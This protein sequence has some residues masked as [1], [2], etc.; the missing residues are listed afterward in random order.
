MHEN[1]CC[2]PGHGL[3]FVPLGREFA[4]AQTMSSEAAAHPRIAQAI[5]DVED[6]IAYMEAAPNDFGGP[7]RRV[8]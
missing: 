2:C 4:N 7:L 8:R 1:A 3:L 5:R 6:V